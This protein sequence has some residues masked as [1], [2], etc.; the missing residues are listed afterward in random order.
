MLH[1]LAARTL[2]M[3]RDHGCSA[4]D[5]IEWVTRRIPATLRD[6]YQLAILRLVLEEV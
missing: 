1:A 5:A 4:A 3:I 2:I 6:Y